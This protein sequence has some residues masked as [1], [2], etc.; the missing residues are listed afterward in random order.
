M[1]AEST[2]FTV[3]AERER[4]QP[5]GLMGGGGGATMKAI[6][7]GG[8]RTQQVRN[9]G[10]YILKKGDEFQIHTA[11]G[12]GYGKPTRRNK[13]MIE[14]DVEDGLLNRSYARKNYGNIR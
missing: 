4:H 6:L 9:K 5:W 12:G 3:L 10:T 7:V 8:A 13:K 14:R 2:T 11:G 1:L